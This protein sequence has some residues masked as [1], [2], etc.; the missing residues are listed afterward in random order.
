MPYINFQGHW[1]F[2]STEEDFLMFSP[3]IGMAAIL[4]CDL[5][6]LNKF[7]FPHHMDDP[8]DLWL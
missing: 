8:H 6:R 2:G 5:D 7:L 1:P 3:N 4:S